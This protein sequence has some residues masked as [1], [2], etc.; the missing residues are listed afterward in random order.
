MDLTSPLGSSEPNKEFFMVQPI[1]DDEI[2]EAGGGET[3]ASLDDEA[4]DPPLPGG[5]GH[6]LSLSSSIP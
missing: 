1:K 2:E 3:R 6:P 5:R 4:P